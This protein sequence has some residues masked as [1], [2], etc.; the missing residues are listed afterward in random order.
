MTTFGYINGELTESILEA[1]KKENVNKLLVNGTNGLEEDTIE[2][3]NEIIKKLSH[4]DKLVIYDFSNLKLTLT[5]LTSF[6]RSLKEKKVDLKIIN[7]DEAFSTMTDSEFIE[8][9]EDLSRENQEVLKKRAK[10]SSNRSK[11]SGR[12]KI[13][14][15]TIDRM[16][17]LRYEKNYT[18]KDIAV[19]CGVSIGTAYKYLDVKE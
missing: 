7:K 10:V 19:I 13:S 11:R 18:L 2:F 14:Q 16:N 1:F 5:E 17:Y 12:P 9:I 8:F 15:E 3:L 6:F 4:S